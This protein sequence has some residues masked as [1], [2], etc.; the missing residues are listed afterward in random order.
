MSLNYNRSPLIL[1]AMAA[2]AMSGLGLSAEVA[3]LGPQ[4]RPQ[5]RGAFGA[6]KRKQPRRRLQRATGP[7]SYDEWKAQLAAERAAKRL[8][9][10]A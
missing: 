1:A 8:R 3:P 4:I 7:G 6:L 9:A 10:A 2:A 5:I